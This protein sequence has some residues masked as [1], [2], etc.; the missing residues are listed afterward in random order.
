M[1]DQACSFKGQ[2]GA[3]AASLYSLSSLF[4]AATS[5][6]AGDADEYG[7]DYTDDASTNV[8]VVGWICQ[9]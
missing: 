8:D 7:G 4:S 1:K 2:C 3:T 9:P 5:D 6:E